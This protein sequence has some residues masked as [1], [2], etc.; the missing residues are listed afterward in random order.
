MNNKLYIPK[1]LK[2]GFNYRQDTYSK[3]LAYVTYFD[4]KNVLRKK[5][6]WTGW[7]QKPGDKIESYNDTLRKWE[8]VEI[9]TDYEPIELPN[10]PISGFVLNKTV[11][12]ARESYGWNARN[13]Y[14]RCY[15][16]R[17]FEIELKI[18]NLIFILQ[19][20]T[21][22]KGKG[23]EGEFVYSWLGAELILLPVDSLEY[24][25]SMNY[26]NLQ[27]K[28]I[29][30]NEMKPGRVY[31]FKDT[32]VAIY[33][34]RF[35]YIEKGREG[36]KKHIFVTDN[37][38][39]IAQAGFTKLSEIV[40]DDIVPNLA[41]LVEAYQKTTYFLSPTKLVFQN[42]NINDI[43]I[44]N[45]KHYSNRDAYQLYYDKV[46]TKYNSEEKLGA[47]YVTDNLGNTYTINNIFYY[48][49]Y[50]L[51]EATI[52]IKTAEDI[53]KHI[54]NIYVFYV[55]NGY[56]NNGYIKH[57]L[58]TKNNMLTYNYYD[59]VNAPNI[60]K[61]IPN[62]EYSVEKYTIINKNWY[63]N[64][65]KYTLYYMTEE[66]FKNNIKNCIFKRRYIELEDGQLLNYY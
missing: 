16:P 3:K 2:V 47:F 21:S 6:S 31:K 30:R 18:P 38:E 43:K 8:N 12:G 56:N 49:R 66:Q 45:E 19:E 13:E 58:D 32:T 22:T 37:N 5:K 41:E 15:D 59:N 35:N 55:D 65:K 1:K 20:C 40:N 44:D 17:G 27:S 63:N 64:N 54:N 50:N 62:L 14:V 39:Y 29:T 34:G 46:K 42:I 52:D 48:N 51:E 7:I 4:D 36:K 10:E 53:T 24:K 61:S 60:I 33:L 11:G 9:P 28:K 23:L 26:T 25:E 57:T